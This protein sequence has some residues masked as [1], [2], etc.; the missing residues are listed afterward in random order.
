MTHKQIP[1]AEF[2]LKALEILRQIEESGNSVIVMDTVCRCLR[3]SRVGARGAVRSMRCAN[4][5]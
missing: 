2:K 4:P 5:W 1:K 3:S